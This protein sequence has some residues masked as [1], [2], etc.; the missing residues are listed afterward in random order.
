MPQI[1]SIEPQKKNPQRFNIFLDGKFAFGVKEIAV[2]EHNLKIGKNITEEDV[3]N[4]L[5]KEEIGRLTDLAAHFLSYRPRSEKEVA[6]YLIKKISLRQKIK[7]H[8][9]KESLQIAIVIKKLKKYKYINDQQFAKWFI[10][11]RMRSKPKGKI[12]LRSELKAKGVEED[13][14]A[15]MLEGAVNELELA[16]KAIQKKIKRWQNLSNLDLKK[17]VYMYL[18]ARGFS[19]EIIREIFANLPKKG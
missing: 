13:L 6:D 10:E 17:K 2:F 18:G 16:Q 8:E 19:V 9:A 1:T 15:K 4:I 11:S 5:A 3:T 12:A 7:F 14:I